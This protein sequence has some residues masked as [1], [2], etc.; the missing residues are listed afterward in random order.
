MDRKCAD[1]AEARGARDCR[2]SSFIHA[3]EEEPAEGTSG[4]SKR[5]E[6][7]ASGVESLGD[8]LPEGEFLSRH[9][10]SPGVTT[11]WL[12]EVVGRMKSPHLDYRS[13]PSSIL[14]TLTSSASQIRNNVVSVIGRPGLDLLRSVLRRILLRHA[15]QLVETG[16]GS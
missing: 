13:T 8:R 2:G 6:G 4:H 7:I 1:L 11:E 10:R 14:A 5:A 3:V 9:S 12:L 15:T 16:Q